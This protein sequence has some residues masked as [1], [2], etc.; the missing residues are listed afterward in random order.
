M[1]DR[2][3]CVFDCLLALTEDAHAECATI[4]L[5]LIHRQCNQFRKGIFSKTQILTHIWRTAVISNLLWTESE[6]CIADE[7]RAVWMYILQWRHFVHSVRSEIHLNAAPHICTK[8]LQSVTN[9]KHTVYAHR[10]TR[11][12]TYNIVFISLYDQLGW[13]F[14]LI[15]IWNFPIARGESLR[16][17]L[18]SVT[19][20]P[21]HLIQH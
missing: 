21:Y 8:P 16:T 5:G 7:W 9:F 19:T 3:A 4:Q 17:E 14:I 11:R 6:R 13:P 15:F 1:N 20:S 18:K 12:W 10:H 2:F